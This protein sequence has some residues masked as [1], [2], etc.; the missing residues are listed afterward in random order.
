MRDQ[1]T[2]STSRL[3]Q[4]IFYFKSKVVGVRRRGRQFHSVGAATPNDHGDVCP[5]DVDL[6]LVTYNGCRVPVSTRCKY[7]YVGVVIY[8]NCRPVVVIIIYTL[9]IMFNRV[10]KRVTR[11]VC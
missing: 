4:G 7:H 10:R 2:P 8:V 5:W 6:I 9:Y 3:N 1:C 11:N